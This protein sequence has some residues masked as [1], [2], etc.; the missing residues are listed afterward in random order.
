MCNFLKSIQKKFIFMI[1][2]IKHFLTKE[3]HNR[4]SELYNS[5]KENS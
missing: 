2:F 1:D 4:S 3:E 5:E